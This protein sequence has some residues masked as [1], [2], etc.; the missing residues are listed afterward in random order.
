[1]D[2][3]T[4]PIVEMVTKMK[5]RKYKYYICVFCFTILPLP[6]EPSVIL[7]FWGGI[8]YEGVK[9]VESKFKLINTNKY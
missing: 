7:L 3:F 5:L 4:L 8:E 6:H 2:K 9:D 1:M